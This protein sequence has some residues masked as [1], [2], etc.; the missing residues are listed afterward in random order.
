[1]RQRGSLNTET[2]SAANYGNRFRTNYSYDA[3]GNILNL[4]RYSGTATLMDNISYTYSGLNNRLMS[5]TDPISTPAI[6]TDIEGTSNFNYDAIGN[7]ISDSNNDN[8]Q[9][10]WTVYGKVKRV[11]FNNK[12]DLWFGYNRMGNRV[13]KRVLDS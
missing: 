3:D 13:V 12:A 8:S 9:I 7:L 11:D 6:T 5:V 1:M 2:W 4:K 10:T